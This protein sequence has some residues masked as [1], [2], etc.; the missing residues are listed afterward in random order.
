M[1]VED[2]LFERRRIEFPIGAEFERYFGHPVRLA[3][4]VDS[5]SVCLALRNAHDCVEKR[6]SEK[7]QCAED[8]RQ[9]RES[10]WI[11]NPAYAPFVAPA[12][13]CRVKK[14]LSKRG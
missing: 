10:G 11:G 7:N 12:S 13:G 6:R 4:C 5:K 9:Q 1:I 8:Q 14:N 2:E 3:G